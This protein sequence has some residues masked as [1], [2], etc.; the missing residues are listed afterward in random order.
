M[1]RIFSIW[2]FAHYKKSIELILHLFYII[3]PVSD[4]DRPSTYDDV[5]T[6]MWTHPR[7]LATAGWDSFEP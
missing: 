4:F 5:A 6:A 1:E 2:I 3:N 7:G